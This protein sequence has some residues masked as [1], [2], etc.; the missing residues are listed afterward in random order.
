[1]H[2]ENSAFPSLV[3]RHSTP[4]DTHRKIGGEIVRRVASHSLPPRFFCACLEHIWR[5][6]I[7]LRAF[8]YLQFVCVIVNFNDIGR[9][10]SHSADEELA[11]KVHP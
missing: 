5:E 4:P 11:K 10:I 1:M 6:T 9:P 8:P 2:S 3:P 7:I